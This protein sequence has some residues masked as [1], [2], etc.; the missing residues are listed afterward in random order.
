VIGRIRYRDSGDDAA[1][2]PFSTLATRRPEL[3]RAG[4]RY[5]GSAGLELSDDAP[6]GK[7]WRE[8]PTLDEWLVLI[9]DY[10]LGCLRAHRGER[11]ERRFSERQVALRDLGFVLTRHGVR[12]DDP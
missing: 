3:A 12:S 9:S 1:R 11:A 6:R 5:L 2:V 4:L 10:A 7:G 8:P